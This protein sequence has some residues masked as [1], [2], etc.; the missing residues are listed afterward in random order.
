MCEEDYFLNVSRKPN[1]CW[2][3]DEHAVLITMVRATEWGNKC[4]IQGFNA[5]LDPTK[6]KDS[7]YVALEADFWCVACKP[8]YDRTEDGR[9][10]DR[11]DD[12]DR[13]IP[14]CE[15][16]IQVSAGK[17]RCYQC[18]WGYI[19]IENGK[20]CLKLQDSEHHWRGCRQRNRKNCTECRTTY[21]QHNL[22]SNDHCVADPM[23]YCG[24]FL[25]VDKT[26]CECRYNALQQGGSDN[27]RCIPLAD[28]TWSSKQENLMSQDN[29]RDEYNDSTMK[30]AIATMV[31]ASHTFP[32]PP[33]GNTTV[34]GLHNI[35]QNHID[36]TSNSGED[37]DAFVQ[38][39]KSM[40]KEH[41]AW[42][43]EGV[44]EDEWCDIFA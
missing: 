6:K 18:D 44:T 35:M 40:T 20:R 17:Q 36:R 29:A 34:V 21:Y 14:N 26:A 19:S 25:N 3:N 9:C 2:K 43:T 10:L 23:L 31:C 15:Q 16:E 13:L 37:V 38:L 8:G 11:A 33:T 1:V 41:A 24:T 12:V 32:N 4:E 5:E 22:D 7:K 27:N 42:L 30:N 28:N 39:Q